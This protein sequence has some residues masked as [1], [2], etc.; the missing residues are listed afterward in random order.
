MCEHTFVGN[1]RAVQYELL[2]GPEG[3]QIAE[4]LL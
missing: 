1:S 4:I 3:V 2:I